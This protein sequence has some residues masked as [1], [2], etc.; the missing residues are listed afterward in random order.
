L[1]LVVLWWTVVVE[2]LRHRRFARVV[3]RGLLGEPLDAEGLEHVPRGG[4]FVL[5]ANHHQA[6]ST[7]QVMAAVLGAAAL[8]RPGADAD[9]LVVIGQR[10]APAPTRRLRLARR[11]AAAFFGRWERN[12]LRVPT[13]NGAPVLTAL[14]VWR[15]RAREQPVL[16]FPEGVAGR[17]FARVRPG[18]GRWLSGVAAPTL[19]VAVWRSARGWRVVFGAPV[20]WSHRVELRDLQL[21][22][23]IAAML[24]EEMAPGWQGVLGAWRA[25]HAGRR[26]PESRPEPRI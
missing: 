10:V 18:A 13:G 5:A 11:L 21:G 7:F 4:S 19:P 2:T 12:V 8:A 20:V 16:V 1:P 23:A 22:L 25:A 24:P 26:G 9:G 17:M 14:R 15:R 6:G 3:A